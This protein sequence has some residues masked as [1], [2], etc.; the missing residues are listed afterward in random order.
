MRKVL[1]LLFI[2]MISSSAYP[3]FTPYLNL[4]GAKEYT[5]NVPPGEAVI[6]QFK[7][8]IIA[9]VTA[10]TD[11]GKDFQI[12]KN[13]DNINVTTLVKV[14]L[15]I[16]MKDGSLY[17]I[18]LNPLKGTEQRIFVAYE[19]NSG[20]E[21]PEVKA[22]EIS[23]AADIDYRLLFKLMFNYP[24]MKS[25]KFPM[26]ELNEKAVDYT[27]PSGGTVKI[28]PVS[29]FENPKKVGIVYAVLNDEADNLKLLEYYFVNFAMVEAKNRQL[30]RPQAIRIDSFTLNTGESTYLYVVYDTLK[31]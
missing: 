21:A 20:T 24:K 1:L 13:V 23:F 5:L 17:P 30:L 26:R 7:D 27:L 25:A 15:A 19:E 31:Q 4:Q 2:V 6:I 16:Q 29:A 11:I 28:V 12:I 22:T 9:S 8:R 18:T 10:D 14:T 3:G